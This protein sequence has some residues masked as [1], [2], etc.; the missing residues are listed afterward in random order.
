M[1]FTARKSSFCTRHS[2][3]CVQVL[4]EFAKPI[5][6]DHEVEALPS[7]NVVVRNSSDPEGPSVLFTH[8]EWRD[9]IDGAKA[10]E[11]DLP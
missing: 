3:C 2:C 11:F 6:T 7:G 8:A 4:G 10:G 9:F 5:G 1:A